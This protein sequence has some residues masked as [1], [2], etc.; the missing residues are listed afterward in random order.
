MPATKNVY[1]K[2]RKNPAYI[3]HV[4]ATKQT[5][6]MCYYVIRRNPALMRHCRYQ[7]NLYSRLAVK[8]NAKLFAGLRT[9]S[10]W[11]AR[12]LVMS[13]PTN[14]RHISRFL[15]S[16]KLLQLCMFAP[17]IMMEMLPMAPDWLAREYVLQH[18]HPILYFVHPAQRKDVELCQVAVHKSPNNMQYVPACVQEELSALSNL[19]NDH[20]CNM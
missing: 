20:Q 16:E 14:I 7:R 17:H 5:E 12:Y 6:N 15:S 13:N 11:M 18:P 8:N 19:H 2:L 9:R 3:R 10:V 4:P 1:A